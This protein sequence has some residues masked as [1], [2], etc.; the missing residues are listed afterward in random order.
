MGPPILI[1]ATHL[2]GRLNGIGA[3]ILNL[4]REWARMPTNLRF[5]VRADPNA[6]A[7]LSSIPFP[8]NLTLRWAGRAL[9]GGG[10]NRRR[11]LYANGMAAAHPKQVLFNPSQLEMTLIGAR[12]IV[13][14]HD[15]IPLQVEGDYLGPQR[16]FYRL[17]VRRGIQRAAAVIVPSQAT[18]DALLAAFGT[19]SSRP[20]VI[21]HGVR[22]LPA[23][24]E[25]PIQRKYVLFAGRIV[26]YR[27]LERLLEAFL[28]ISNRVPHDLVLV[29]EAGYAPSLPPGGRVTMLGYVDDATLGAL[30]RG[31]SAFV[32]PSLVEGFGFPPLEAMSCGCPVIASR[33][34]GLREVLG[35]AA[36]LVDPLDSGE[37][38]AA[39]LSVLEDEELRLRLARQGLERAARFTWE[40]S[41]RE[42]LR[43]FEEVSA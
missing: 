16:N 23:G 8:E 18:A 40:R 3:Y 7:H 34:P 10:S 28:R 9:I 36:V 11:F 37:I 2:G 15:T 4:L 6:A 39:L 24:G 42:H 43:I 1:N 22:A 27:N 33:E 13:T 31:A 35:D 38:A 5:D 14:V 19:P 17:V 29:G 32:F 12:Q 25:S 41:A 21:P 20:R 30:Y 26:P